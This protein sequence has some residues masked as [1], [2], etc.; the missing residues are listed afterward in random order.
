[1]HIILGLVGIALS[2][3]MIRHRESVGDT[4]GDAEWMHKLGGVYNVVVMSSILLFLISVAAI[5]NLTSVA[6]MPIVRFLMPFSLKT[7]PA[8]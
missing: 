5:F 3:F 6:L 4:I 2:F 7:P 1:M 8:P